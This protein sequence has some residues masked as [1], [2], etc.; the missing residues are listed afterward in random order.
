MALVGRGRK[1]VVGALERGGV[2][3][4]DGER[5]AVV[6]HDGRRTDVIL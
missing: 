4:L 5:R 2:R 3:Q 1:G 6:S